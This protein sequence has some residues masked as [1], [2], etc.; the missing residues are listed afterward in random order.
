MPVLI[1]LEETN[2]QFQVL[3]STENIPNY[4][5]ESNTIEM[6][7]I[8]YNREMSTGRQLSPGGLPYA[9]PSASICGPVG[10]QMR[11]DTSNQC[12]NHR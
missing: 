12:L 9:S 8:A 10:R 2:P 5:V 1:P 11:A 3:P 7:L 4:S 6:S